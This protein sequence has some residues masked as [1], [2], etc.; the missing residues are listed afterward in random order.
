MGRGNA[1]LH[2]DRLGVNFGAS[3]PRSD[4][5]AIPEQTPFATP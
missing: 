1:V 3:D 2:D 4:G 5:E